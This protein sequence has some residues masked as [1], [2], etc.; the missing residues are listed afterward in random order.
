MDHKSDMIHI[1]AHNACVLCNTND[2]GYLNL[3]I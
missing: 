2:V 3:L 1:M